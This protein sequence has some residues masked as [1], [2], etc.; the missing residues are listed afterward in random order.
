MNKNLLLKIKE[1]L[2]SVLPITVIV[3]ILHMT[4]SPIPK[5]TLALFLVGTVFL[6]I[7]MGLFTLGADLAM[8][9]MGELV[10]AGIAKSKKLIF[11][12][13]VSLIF[14]IIITVAEPDLQVLA[15]QV[16]SVPDPIIIW[17]V[18]IGVGVFLVIALLRIVFQLRLS[19]LLLIFYIG[20]FIIAAFTSVDFLSVAFDSGGVTTGPITVPFIMAL[21]LGI[22]TVRGD[23]ASH[24]DSF[25]LVALCSVGPILAV[26]LMA[27]FY[28]PTSGTYEALS[29]I[30]VHSIK[31]LFHLFIEEIPHYMKEVAIALSP[32]VGF[33]GLFQVFSLKLNHRKIA[34]IIIGVLYTYMGLVIFLTGVN[35]GF[36]P[37]GKYLGS[38]IA[39]LPYNQILIPLGMVMGFFIVT[40]EPAVHVLTKQ[41]E[42]ITGGSISRKSILASLSIGIA[43]SVGLAM[44]RVLTGISIWYMIL[45]GYGIALILTFFVPKIFTA[46]AFDSGGVASGPMTATF[47]LPFAMGA[48]EQLGGNVLSDAFG[49]VAMVAMT[50]LVTIQ[51]LGLVYNIKNR[52]SSDEV[53][54]LPNESE[55]IIDFEEDN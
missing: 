16:P 22:S 47:L 44:L 48:C 49:I 33:F 21:G 46:I 15:R 20:L 9:P 5:G 14:G 51:I 24:D 39:S 25:G 7:G 29:K 8:M 26:L 53:V 55:E 30:E 45:P 17:S 28:N 19:Y 43:I 31:E 42:N 34:K 3:L 6:I 13:I 23:K 38:K 18:A 32:I 10:G 54:L 36:L 11:M 50:P 1:S 12:V 40:A 52:I 35:L 2:T 41:V 37:V 27:L 4:I